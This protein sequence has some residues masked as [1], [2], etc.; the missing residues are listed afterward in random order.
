MVTIFKNIYDKDNPVYVPVEKVLSAIHKGQYKNKIHQV[1]QEKD[2]ASRARI[3]NNLVSVC[4]S[5]KFKK[6]YDADIIQH[7]GFVILD[8]DHL[9]D[10]QKT[11][12]EI[13]K[14]PFTFAAFVSPSGDGLKVLVK[15]PAKKEDHEAHYLALMN[16]YPDLDS[17][18]KNISRVCFV[19]YDPELYHN[20]K[21]DVFTKKGKI[22]ETVRREFTEAQRTDYAKLNIAAD[23]IR[24][25]TDG[26]KHHNLI[27]AARL[28][29]GFIA[30]G[31]VEEHEAVRVLEQEINQKDINDFKGACKTIQD[32]IVYGKNSPIYE[33]NHKEKIKEIRNSEII[34][35]D[36]PPKD[37]VFLNDVR[38]KIIYSYT[39]GTSRGETTHF[40]DIDNHF[41]HKRGEITLM[42]GIANHGKS[43]M[44]LQLLLVKAVKDGY[45]YGIFSP[46]NMPEEDFYKDLMHPLV[47]KSP[48]K[49]HVNQMSLR[50]R[51][52][53]MDFLHEHFFLVYPKDDAPTPQYINSRF[54]ELLIKKGVDGCVIDPY[55]QL[56]NDM[57][58]KNNREDQYISMV[59]TSAKRFAVEHNLFYYIVTH[60]KGNLSKDGVDYECPNVFDLSGGAM[61]NNKCDNILVTHR[62]YN[63]SDKK[64]TEVHLKSQ[65]IKKQKLN[66]IPGDV[67]LFFDRLTARYYQVDGYN[68]LGEKIQGQIDAFAGIPEG[69]PLPF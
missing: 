35:E 48:E 25:S 26:D 5:G 64:D 29:G 68:P 53:A 63:T 42:H 13:I 67:I 32:G 69:E 43:Q 55:N 50:E 11:K 20:P 33:N 21:S 36:E 52:D 41:R 38:D 8:F 30:G 54:R 62:P 17:T 22:K 15:I 60:P 18:S 16:K 61:W 66:G 28:I 46:E 45:K 1:R 14:D 51:D 47:G 12:D 6:R 49:H 4:F 65:K 59:L 31:L 27:R 19:S 37:V 57:T 34:I 23:M 44:L 39:H 10:V 58:K 9:K 2:K 3:K 56:D 24:M 7:S 40:P